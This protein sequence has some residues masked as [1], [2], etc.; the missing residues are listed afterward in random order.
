MG[1]ISRGKAAALAAVAVL[2]GTTRAEASVIQY[3]FTVDITLGPLAGTV[4]KGSF[5]L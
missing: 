4:E 3:D 2:A 5:A 1:Q